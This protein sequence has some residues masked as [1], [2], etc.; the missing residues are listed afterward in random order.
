MAPPSPTSHIG[1]ARRLIAEQ[2]ADH[3]GYL[4]V[5]YEA[6]AGWRARYRLAMLL[7]A[8]TAQATEALGS[9]EWRPMGVLVEVVA[10]GR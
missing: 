8:S 9:F 7:G 6:L 4:E 10:D 1:L 5:T 2:Y 3:P